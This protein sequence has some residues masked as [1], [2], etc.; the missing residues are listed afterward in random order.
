LFIHVEH[1]YNTSSENYS[2]TMYYKMHEEEIFVFNFQTVTA[3]VSLKAYAIAWTENHR[4]LQESNL[5]IQQALRA[6]TKFY[7]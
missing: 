2:E 1:L 5:T 3:A 6:P 4:L 7:I